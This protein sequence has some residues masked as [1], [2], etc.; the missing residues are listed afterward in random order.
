MREDLG[1]MGI[2]QDLLIGEAG[3]APDGLAGLFLDAAGQFREGIDLIQRVSAG[4]T[5]VGHAV[6]LDD[7]QDLLHIHPLT[8]VEVPGLRIMTSLASVLAPRTINRRPE[9]RAVGHCLFEDF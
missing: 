9:A 1:E 7:V 4:E 3:P 2:R 8:G 5:H 6:G